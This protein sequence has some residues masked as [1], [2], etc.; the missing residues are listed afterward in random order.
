MREYVKCKTISVQSSAQCESVDYI[1]QP[2]WMENTILVQ[3]VFYVCLSTEF[4]FPRISLG[5]KIA[6][7]F[8]FWDTNMASLT[9]FEHQG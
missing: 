8:L 3:Y 4:S 6:A 1:M 5:L 7:V 9:S 2:L